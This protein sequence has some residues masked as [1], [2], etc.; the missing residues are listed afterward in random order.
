MGSNMEGSRTQR[1]RDPLLDVWRGLALVDMAWVHLALYP[2]GMPDALA[3]WIGQHTRFAA[4]TFVLVSGIAVARV[5]G[6]AL[7]E[8][9]PAGVEARWRL[10]RRAA[11]L[12]VLDRLVGIL[13]VLLESFRHSAPELTARLPLIWD[14]LSFR[15]PGVTGGL[16]FLYSLLLLATPVMEFLRQR[17]GGPVLV[18]LSG[19]VYVLGYTLSSGSLNDQW[20]FPFACWQP[21][22]VLGYVGSPWFA[23]LSAGQAPRWWFVAP[24]AVFALVFLVRNGGALGLPPELTAGSWFVKVPLSPAELAWYV[25]ASLAVATVTS[26]SWQRF[27]AARP[28]LG[29]F[30]QLGRK[31]LTVYV[32]HLLLEVPL[33]EIL[34]LLDPPAIVRATAL[35]WMAGALFLV[36]ASAEAIDRLLERHPSLLPREVT[37]TVRIPRGLVVG[38]GVALGALALVILAQHGVGPTVST[39][40]EELVHEGPQSQGSSADTLVE[41]ENAPAGE[42]SIEEAAME[43]PLSGEP[44]LSP[45]FTELPLDE[46]LPEPYAP[47]PGE[48]WQSEPTHEGIEPLP[49]EQNEARTGRPRFLSLV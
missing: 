29:L 28:V 5:F 17:W 23:R 22:F 35:L 9:A 42:V 49:D 44:S 25:L 21:L 32:A 2:I 36:A 46:P 8:R 1:R 10:M 34:T 18:A 19:A 15:L 27:P 48:T 3:Q 20:P 39:G 6:S 12:F 40:L 24:G 13:F 14:L 45:P 37:L 11:L 41:L 31:S 4:G 7:L 38:T 26:W 47:F 33:L 43:N 30:A 16:L